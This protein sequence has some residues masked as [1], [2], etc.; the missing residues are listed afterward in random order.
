MNYRIRKMQST[1]YHAAIQ[2]WESLSG[3]GLSG[4]DKPEEIAKFLSKNPHTSFIAQDDTQLIGTI[5]G[6]SD[7]RRGYIYHLAVQADRQNEGVGRALLTHCLDAYREAGLQKCHIFVIA[8]N[9]QGI[10]FWE[11]MGWVKRHDI[12]A[13]SKD[14]I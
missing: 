11:K 6:G 13:M 10:A 8:D 1:D 7:G 2:L 9:S 4:A 5:L 12:L 14:L 3:I